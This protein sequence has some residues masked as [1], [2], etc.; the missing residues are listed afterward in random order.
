[1]N[2][3]GYCSRAE[4]K[5]KE[6]KKKKAEMQMQNA[7]RFNYPNRTLMTLL[8]TCMIFWLLMLGLHSFCWNY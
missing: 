5:K 7:L 2:N 8:V 1:M 6:K 4:K 3:A